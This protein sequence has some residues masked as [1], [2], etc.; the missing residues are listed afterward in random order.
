ML[1]FFNK[2]LVA[3]VLAL[4]L[5]L[6]ITGIGSAQ[7]LC[8][9]EIPAE[10]K[11][12][13]N[14]I[15]MVPD[16]MGLPHTTLARWYKG[17]ELLT[18]DE[19][20]CGLVR[21]HASDSA[22]TDS[23]PA[24]TVMATGH[25]SH[26]GFVGT[27]PDV[28]NMPGLDPIE[29]GEERRPVAN[30][31]EAAKLKGLAT[32]LVAT[33]QIPHATPAGFSA[34]YPDRDDYE[35]LIEQQV[36]N[37]IDV[38][39]GGGYD[40]LKKR[41]DNENL[42][43]TLKQRGY[44][45]ITTRDELSKIKGNKVWGMF[46]PVDM[47]YELD[48]PEHE[49]TLAEMTQKALEILSKDSDG[50]FLMVEGSKIDWAAHANDP[51]GVI[52]DVI[53]FDDAVK[54]ALD[55]AL[56]DENTAIVVAADHFTGGMSIGNLD[57]DYDIQH[58]SAFIEPLKKAKVTGEGLEKKLN[59]DRSNITEVMK[60][61]FGIDDLTED[62][63]HAIAAAEA[64]AVD[65]VVGPIISSRALLGWTSHGHAGNDV[66][67]YMYHPKGYRYCGVI[68]NADINKYM[69][70]VLD[71]DLAETT[72]R[73]FVNAYEAFT[74]KGATLKVDSKDPENPILVVTK[75]N[76]QIKLPVNK[77]IAFVDGK[78]IQLPGVIVYTGE[79]DELDIEKW[80]VS[81]DVIELIK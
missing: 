19:I 5:L 22:I 60:E 8:V 49:P 55:F 27:L 34:H 10:Q 80:Y 9:P 7:Q 59:S 50:F 62:E 53:A 21:T 40:Y 75:G 23:A 69:Q 17:G 74:A 4:V 51:V 64:D 81:Y 68:D 43:S 58:I 37:S 54:V 56:N 39:F 61:F 65:E 78:Q 70:E 24:A 12:V 42:F 1:K 52:S 76:I 26:S 32:G 2:R 72:E 13:K 35:L 63:I 46:A 44:E 6:S 45:Y 66:V 48:R 14:M 29:P 25:K 30:I 28:A 41:K 38:V 36:F 18:M 67:L 20:A 73:L 79:F 3:M 57:E 71:I 16:G 31:L 33:C 77:D 15:L 11:Q 47:A